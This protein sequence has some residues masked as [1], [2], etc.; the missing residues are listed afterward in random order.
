MLDSGPPARP[1]RPAPG[2][3]AGPSALGGLLPPDLLMQA[4]GRVS[5]VA[6]S[7]AV[8]WAFWLMIASTADALTTSYGRREPAWHHYGIQTALL[9]IAFSLLVA[10]WARRLQA[11]PGAVL[12]LGLVFQ[13]V[14]AALIAF[15]QSWQPAIVGRG[16]SWVCVVILVYPAVVPSRPLVTV[17]TSLLA[18]AMD[19]LIHL[20]AVRAGESQPVT[21]EEW[22]I[23]YAPNAVCAFL[24]VIP[25]R[26]VNRLS[27]AVEEAREIGNYRLGKQIGKGGMGEVYLASHRLLARPAAIKIISASQLG[28]DPAARAD[29][30]ERFRREAEAAALLR[31]PHTIELYDFGFSD[32]GA[33]YYAMELLE[34]LTLQQLVERFGAQ[35][36]G[37]VIHLLRQACLSLAEAHR[38]ELVH[39]DIKPSNLMTCRMGT[40][41]DYLKVLDFGLVKA[42]AAAAGDAALTAADVTAG[43]PDF[44]APEAIDGVHGLDHR[45]DLYALGCV[46]YW[47][48][49]G[50]RVFTG[51]T[52]LA[53]L[54][55]HGRETPPPLTGTAGP[56]AA[57]LEAVVRRC[58]EKDPGNRPADALELDAALANCAQSG[59]WTRKEA[60]RWWDQHA[61]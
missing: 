59:E 2:I 33:L 42:S 25:S 1:V 55:K 20:V 34:G 56:V 24:A 9:A 29:I 50:R 51:N 3:H 13:V 30:E 5:S 27:R 21:L 54:V 7:F 22:M 52:A 32:D 31:S 6:K 15:L 44:M 53:I 61:P 11:R 48:L 18:A 46:G 16:V 4:G 17:I 28:S 58:L 43:T 14:T 39:R 57:D 41:V 12:R 49:A 38:Q 19:P 45:A 23:L 35:P 47:L 10:A 37:R 8:A 26:M 36:A 40:E 60:E